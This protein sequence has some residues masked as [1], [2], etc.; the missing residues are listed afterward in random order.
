MQGS[1]CSGESYVVSVMATT[2][3]PISSLKTDSLAF[4]FS[5]ILHFLKFVSIAH[6][7]KK[8]RF[9]ALLLDIIHS[10]RSANRCI[11]A[12]FSAAQLFREWDAVLPVHSSFILCRAPFGLYW[13]HFFPCGLVCETFCWIS[14]YLHMLF[15]SVHVVSPTMGCCFFISPCCLI[16][17]TA[18]ACISSLS[19]CRL[20]N[21]AL[22]LSTT[23]LESPH[24]VVCHND[25]VQLVNGLL[26]KMLMLSNLVHDISCSI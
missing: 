3:A 18:V 15:S 21:R 20:S 5:V 13:M 19:S 25:Y 12:F 16:L 23:S 9:C 2:S 8:D 11:M 24:L 17:C 26:R 4:N 22:S 1:C 14:P 10:A 7:S 6:L